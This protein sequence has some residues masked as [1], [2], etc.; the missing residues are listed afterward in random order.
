MGLRFD[1]ELYM[2]ESQA[3]WYWPKKGI[4]RTKWADWIEQAKNVDFNV[5]HL[6]LSDEM[7]AKFDEKASND[8][9]FKTQ[10]HIYGVHNFIWG[11]QDTPKDNFPPLL[12]ADIFPILMEMEEKSDPL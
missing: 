7:S 4:Q 8:F 12:N 10:G 2:V 3:G 6:P 5:V 1:G 11:W 9:F